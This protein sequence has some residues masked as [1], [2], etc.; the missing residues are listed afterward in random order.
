M[1]FD[2]EHEWV[3]GSL[4]HDDRVRCSMAN[5]K[6]RINGQI[7]TTVR[8]HPHKTNREHVLVPLHQVAEWLVFNWHQLLYEAENN[9][10]P[11]HAGF[12]S[13]HNLAF[14]GDGFILPPLMIASRDGA[15]IMRWT[16]S[17]P[18]F[19][20]MEFTGHGEERV[21]TDEVENTFQSLIE[22]VLE[23]M[24]QEKQPMET[25]RE[26]WES[27]QAM[28]EEE[29]E[30]ARAAAL[31]GADPSDIDGELA[32]QIM[33]MWKDICPSLRED[34]LRGI[35]DVRTL[36]KVKQWV[37][38][39]LETLNEDKDSTDTSWWT[40]IRKTMA[41]PNSKIPWRKGYEM[42]QNFRRETLGDTSRPLKSPDDDLRTSYREV[43]AISK[44]LQGLVAA[45]AP[46]CAGTAKNELPR[47]FLQARSIGAFLSSSAAEP[48]I[49]STVATDFQE[50]TSAFA[51]QL[52]A[53]AEQIRIRMRDDRT[54]ETILANEF[55]VAKSV[56][57]Y[58]IQTAE[59]CS[60]QTSSSP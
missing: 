4:S 37:E 24:E 17:K 60:L 47:R 26:E 14:G 34:T 36:P 46:T 35:T 31:I 28:D 41:Q 30:F 42:A 43:N 57:D 27:I 21:P 12:K 8:D 53:P 25:L 3:E 44:R 2:I 29:R 51:A 23:K 39:N 6:I 15:T 18:T 38:H 9:R 58:Q 52:L 13:R 48:S 22:T 7:V 50:F 40:N 19:S 1:S 59:R 49:L 32:D 54:S 5:L 20:E 11:Q 56:I 33:E 45:Q 10:E 16:P 55:R